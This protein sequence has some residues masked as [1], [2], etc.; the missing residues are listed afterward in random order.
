MSPQC[1]SK[2][3]LIQ[4]MKLRRLSQALVTSAKQSRDPCSVPPTDSNPGTQVRAQIKDFGLVSQPDLTRVSF[5]LWRRLWKK[6]GIMTQNLPW[7]I[8]T[9]TVNGMACVIADFRRGLTGGIT[10]SLR[11][12][13]VACFMVPLYTLPKA[14]S[15]CSSSRDTRSLSTSQWSIINALVLAKEKMIRI[16]IQCSGY[17][18]FLFLLVS[19][20]KSS[21]CRLTLRH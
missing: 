19:Q 16:L 9:A 10:E 4:H 1:R 7:S 21:I 18:T 3:E 20:W 15:P 2:V 14:P 17:L 5:R 12:I 8:F 11:D 13:V 6:Y